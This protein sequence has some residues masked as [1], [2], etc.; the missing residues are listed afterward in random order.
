MGLSQK[1][2]F[3]SN[4]NMHNGH[5]STG[6]NFKWSQKCSQISQASAAHRNL[7]FIFTE[8]NL[9]CDL[10]NLK[11][12]HKV[13]FLL[14]LCQTVV[15]IFPPGKALSVRTVCT[16]TTPITNA[17][18][19]MHKAVAHS[20][21]IKWCVVWRHSQPLP[22]VDLLCISPRCTNSITHGF[23]SPELC[24]ENR[25]FIL[26]VNSGADRYG[27]T[28]RSRHKSP[29]VDICTVHM[30]LRR[31]CHWGGASQIIAGTHMRNAE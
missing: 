20:N 9:I 5:T 8:L 6:S 4:A 10:T 15:P 23:P 2:T 22:S 14:S 1:D 26:T 12:Q 25:S 7:T 17:T 29:S 19:N 18:K 13:I 3:K 27:P 21:M 16:K 30:S 28:I 11:T 31:A 24:F